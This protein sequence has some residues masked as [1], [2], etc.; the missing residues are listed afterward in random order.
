MLTSKSSVEPTLAKNITVSVSRSKSHYHGTLKALELI[1][2]FVAEGV[3][4]K[5][6]VVVKPNFVSTKRQLAA[7][8]VDAVRAVLDILTKHYSRRIIVTEGPALSGGLKEG[9]VNFDY[10]KLQDDYDVDFLD[11]NNDDY[12]T[13]MGF[14]SK[15]NPLK[16]C[17][18]K[19]VVESDYRVSVA[20]PKTHNNVIVTLSIKNMA[21]GSL[22]KGDKSKVHQGTKATNLNIAKLSHTVMPHLGVIDGFIGMQGEGPVSGD[23]IDLRIASASTHP[24]SLDAVMSKIMGFD[25][26]TIGYLHHLNLSKKGISELKKI[27]IVGSSIEQAKMRFKPHP[28]YN[29]ILNW[30]E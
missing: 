4:G 19:T 2:K 15:L 29:E 1:E 18:S 9:L 30:M 10:L 12:V 21:V 6:T 22:V 28:N 11:L 3:K 26:S 7:T 14:D 20:L 5:K 16:F 13:V 25:P 8:H 17:L 23:P 24:V 27:K